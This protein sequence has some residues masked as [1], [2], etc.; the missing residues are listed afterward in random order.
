MNRAS[1]LNRN[2]MFG[3][4]LMAIVLLACVYTFLYMAFPSGEKPN[5]VGEG[6]DSIMLV[7]DT[8][9]DSGK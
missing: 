2:L 4:A 1:K 7:I 8:I 3:L 6:S 9:A 5:S